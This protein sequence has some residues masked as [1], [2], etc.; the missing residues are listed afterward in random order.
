MRKLTGALLIVMAALAAAAVAL[1]GSQGPSG[2]EVFQS[3]RCSGCHKVEGRGVGLE[4]KQV[5]KG[6]AGQADRL[7]AY[8]AGEAE[9]LLNPAKARSMAS[10]IRKTK[11]LS[12][13]ERKALVDYL[14]S[15]E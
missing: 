7:E 3:L 2:R 12:P 13:A 11:K 4:L 14:L 5:A 9:P 8:L 15:I 1:A 6:Y 10:Q